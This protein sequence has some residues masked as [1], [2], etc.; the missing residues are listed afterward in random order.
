MSELGYLFHQEAIAKIK[1]PYPYLNNKEK[2][3][4]D[5]AI[6]YHKKELKKYNSNFDL[7]DITPAEYKRANS[8]LMRFVYKSCEDIKDVFESYF[9]DINWTEVEH[10]KQPKL[11]EDLMYKE[12]HGIWNNYNAPKRLISATIQKWRTNNNTTPLGLCCAEIIKREAIIEFKT[13]NPNY[14][15]EYFKKELNKIIRNNPLNKL[16]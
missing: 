8:L 3:V 2:V 1:I 12:Y 15:K 10:H 16:S 6:E 9:K 5:D 4:L 7:K 13:N 11:I 14:N